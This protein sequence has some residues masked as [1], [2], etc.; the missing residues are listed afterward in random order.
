MSVILQCLSFSAS[1]LSVSLSRCS[2][3]N[4][5]T[6]A[7]GRTPGF[8]QGFAAVKPPIQGW[9]FITL[10]VES[11]SVEGSHPAPCPAWARTLWAELA[12]GL[13]AHSCAR[14]ACA[15]SHCPPALLGS[16]A[17]FTGPAGQG[18][19]PSHR[20]THSPSTHPGLSIPS[21]ASA[22]RDL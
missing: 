8:A 20:I 19:Q 5:A 12:V 4:T 3:C 13:R 11:S 14:S 15:H 10:S 21:T 2:G 17:Q 7:E 1:Q 9:V 6:G 16:S 22:G 18:P